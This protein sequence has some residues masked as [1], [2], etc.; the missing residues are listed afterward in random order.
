M[1][2][3]EILQDGHYVGAESQSHRILGEDENG[4]LLIPSWRKAYWH[5]RF[6]PHNPLH[7]PYLL[8]T[9]RRRA[10]AFLTLELT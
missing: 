10:V 4:T 6:N 5:K 1:K 9:K 7:W 2:L 3:A 8:N